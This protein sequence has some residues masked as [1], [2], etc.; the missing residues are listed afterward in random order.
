VW[1]GRAVYIV[2]P[3]PGRELWFVHFEEM[4]YPIFD[5]RYVPALGVT[6]PVFSSVG[7]QREHPLDTVLV[8]ARI[9]L[10]EYTETRLGEKGMCHPWENVKL[11]KTCG[12]LVS[13]SI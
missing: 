7:G 13:E 1:S 12:T 6:N 4:V 11:G 3:D 10:E 8:D 9:Q 5:K 2:Y